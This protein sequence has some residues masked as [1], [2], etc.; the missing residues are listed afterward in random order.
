MEQVIKFICLV[1]LSCF[2]IRMCYQL[3][4]L[5]LFNKEYLNKRGKKVL[6]GSVL[7]LGTMLAKN[8]YNFF[9]SHVIFIVIII[10]TVGCVWYMSQQQKM[11]SLSLILIYY[12]LIALSDYF[13]VFIY[14]IFDQEHFAETVYVYYKTWIPVG[15]FICTRCLILGSYIVLK[16]KWKSDIRLSDYRW[17]LVGTGCSFLVILRMFQHEIA[18]MIEEGKSIS[19]RKMSVLLFGIVCCIVITISFIGRY[20]IIKKE[21]DFLLLREEL[22]EQRY[23]ELE[24]NVYLMHD[25]KHNLFAMKNY[26]NEGNYA[27]L[28]MYLNQLCQEYNTSKGQVWTQNKIWNAILQQK[29]E[30]GE[31]K[32]IVMKISASP[33]VR[34]PFDEREGCT[35]WGNLLD[36]AIEACEK[37]HDKEKWIKV[38]IKGT[39]KILF[40]EITN[41]MEEVSAQVY[42]RLITTKPDKVLHGYGIKS[43][44]RIVEKYDGTLLYQMKD[45]VFGVKISFLDIGDDL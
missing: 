38:I 23:K 16:D 33:N 21:K 2:E 30:Q 25:M 10:L 22:L 29:K 45:G 6:V 13:F 11:E 14:M 40:I 39:Q 18:D 20:R 35:F 3:I 42:E 19:P 36:N 1:G 7:C 44:R 12:S 17:L 26:A 27:G 32:G 5:T 24:K 41:S 8:R 31:S 15:I 34:F 37:V 4:F 43:V 28:C 9:F